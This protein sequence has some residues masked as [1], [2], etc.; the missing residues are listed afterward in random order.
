MPPINTPLLYR[1][2]NLDGHSS[3]VCTDDRF[4]YEEILFLRR[5]LDHK[6]KTINNLVKIINYMHTNSNE[7]GENI[8][9]NT[10]T[11]PIQINATAEEQGRNNVTV[12][13]IMYKDIPLNQTQSEE[14]RNEELQQQL[15][16]ESKSIITIEDRLTEFRK[17]QE[18]KFTKIKEPRV[19]PNSIENLHK[20]DRN[21]TLIVGDS[22]LPGLKK[23]KFQKGMERSKLKTS[24][25]L[26]SMTCTITSSHY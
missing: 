3:N 16:I 4:F 5:E 18:E 15:L 21:T 23:E 9:K 25:E 2:D 22:M 17:K 10:N 19:S 13:I 24:L 11:Q 12:N 8:H 7:S 20:W 26:R 14:N 1:K 6:Q